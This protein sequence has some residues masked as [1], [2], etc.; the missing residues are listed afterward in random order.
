MALNGWM[1]DVF[2]FLSMH[3]EFLRAMHL[4]SVIAWMA[5]MFYLPRL[6][7]YHA[8]TEP[9]S[10]TSETFKVMEHKLLRIIMNPALIAS[11]VF[12]IL[13]LC[14]NPALLSVGWMHAKLLGAVLLTG[15]HVVYAN[16][17]RAFAEDRNT[18]SHI[19]Y[20]WWNEAPTLLMIFIVIMG[21]LE[22]F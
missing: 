22:P 6:F 1:G 9:G 5:G 8:Q 19:F 2:L 16:W 4:I 3:Y 17:R 12:G 15:L 11:W 7:V 20:R 21:V 10:D 13:L 18:K 14:A